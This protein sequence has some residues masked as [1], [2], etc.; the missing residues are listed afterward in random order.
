VE[1][2]KN[3]TDQGKNQNLP[4]TI[5]NV[6]VIQKFAYIHKIKIPNSPTIKSPGVQPK[7]RTTAAAAPCNSKFR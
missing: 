5:N 6:P 7:F 1:E 4:P 2:H 3:R